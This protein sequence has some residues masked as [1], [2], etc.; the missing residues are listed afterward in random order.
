MESLRLALAPGPGL[1]FGILVDEQDRLAASALYSNRNSLKDYLDS[2][3]R[4]ITGSN[5]KGTHHRAHH[6]LATEM[7]ALFEGDKHPGNFDLDFAHVS[8]FQKSVYNILL[9]IPRG[10]VTNY[11][12]IAKIL[13]S[14]PRA[15]GTA[16]ASNPWPV[17]VP[18]HRVV[19]SSLKVGNY[20]M[21]GNP[22]EETSLV[23]KKLLEREGVEFQGDRILP[24][25]TWDPR[26]G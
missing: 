26:E 21:N 16:V 15:V 4:K 13:G 17:F 18:C 5:P 24:T 6:R 20:S 14:G 1:W 8:G 10:Y 19:P 23:K 3:A 22:S 9:K 25:S 12:R 7:I 2:F 11:W